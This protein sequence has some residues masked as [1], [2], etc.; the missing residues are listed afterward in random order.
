M[1]Q[2]VDLGSG[3]GEKARSLLTAFGT[4]VIY[5]PVDVSA[6][7]LAQ[8]AARLPEF[9]VEPIQAEFVPGL[10][11]ASS[12]RGSRPLLVTFLG[13]NIGNFDLSAIPPFLRDIRQQLRTGDFLLLGIDLVKPVQ[14]LIAAYDDQSGITAA[15]N[16]NLLHRLNREFGANF[17]PECFQHQARWNPS[18]R[19]IEMHLE[20]ISDQRVFVRDLDLEC[21][22]RGGETIHTES[23][24]KFDAAEM[25][26][27]AVDAGFH[28]IAEWTDDE[29]PFSELLFEVDAR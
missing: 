27:W 28:P 14:Q 21:L 11:I 10:A 22:V 1:K 20:A 4:S 9:L 15:F 16:L 25:R 26:E 6:A 3:S 7:A 2:I 29:W 24:H 18:R 23:S 5:S 12:T 8:C 19:R 17:Q 13:S